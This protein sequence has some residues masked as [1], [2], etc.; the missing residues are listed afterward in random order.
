MICAK[1]AGI[2]VFVTGGIGG[3]HRGAETTFDISADLRELGTTQVNWRFINF[4]FDSL[5]LFITFFSFSSITLIFYQRKKIL[6]W[7]EKIDLRYCFQ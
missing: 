7:N 1:Y 2:Q 5:T 4:G 3:V 6:N